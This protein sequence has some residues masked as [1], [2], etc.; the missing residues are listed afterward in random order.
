ME[1]ELNVSRAKLLDLLCYGTMQGEKLA[2]AN[3]VYKIG[4][5]VEAVRRTWIRILK[6]LPDDLQTELAEMIAAGG[7]GGNKP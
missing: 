4:Q 3:D 1:I 7:E 6:T 5:H 2:T